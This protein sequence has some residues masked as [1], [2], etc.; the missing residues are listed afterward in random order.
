MPCT[1]LRSA[2]PDGAPCAHENKTDTPDRCGVVVLSRRT[3]LIL[4][5]LHVVSLRSIRRFMSFYNISIS[6]YIILLSYI[7]YATI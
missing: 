5:L 4:E 6:H 3:I 2:R 7:R 1:R